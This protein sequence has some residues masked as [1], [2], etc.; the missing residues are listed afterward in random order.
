MEK[1]KQ[2]WSNKVDTG[3]GT[4]KQFVEHYDR[5]SISDKMF[6]VASNLFPN[7]NDGSTTG[8]YEWVIYYKVKPQ[9]PQIE[10][11]ENGR[12]SLLAGD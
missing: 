3:E 12:K 5:I 4:L 11:I 1:E 7:I 2:Y 10:V 8:K 6:V 9:Q